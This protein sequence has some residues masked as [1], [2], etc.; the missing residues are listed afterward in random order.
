MK[1]QF[2]PFRD[3]APR[4]HFPFVNYA[5]IIIN[6]VVF[7]WTYF[8]LPNFDQVIMTWGFISAYPSIVTIFTSMFLHG[9]VEHVV[10][11]MWYLWIFGDNVEDRFGKMGYIML[12]LLSG[13]AATFLDFFTSIGSTVPSIG[14][15]GAI[16]GI[17]GSYIVL[18]P[19][20]KVLA[21][22]E[23]FLAN[24]PAYIVIGLWF[25]L[26]FFLGVVGGGGDVAVWAHVGGF[27]FGAVVTYVLLKL[28][29]I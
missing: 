19:R 4:K 12:Y 21:G 27:I 5:L 23:G 15:S 18:Y 11:N 20:E 29:K 16:A 10:G 9:S 26:Q 3:S 2:F 25:V 6:I 28:N 24:I 8:F 7:I 13:I 14:A 17:L 1:G 22:F